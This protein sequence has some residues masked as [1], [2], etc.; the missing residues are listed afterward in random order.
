[1]AG[2]LFVAIE[3]QPLLVNCVESGLD[4]FEFLFL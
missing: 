2:L 3:R 1:M 4:S